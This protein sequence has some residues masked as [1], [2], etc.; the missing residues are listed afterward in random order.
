MNLIK[1]EEQ[2][3][4]IAEDQ[5]EYK[6][7]PA[8]RASDGRVTCCWQLTWKERFKIFWNG[9]MWHQIL[10]FHNSLQPQLLSTE[11]PELEK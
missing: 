3:M 5:P 8:H 2:N 1:F 11:K 4:V 9:I 7:M 10:T 6:S